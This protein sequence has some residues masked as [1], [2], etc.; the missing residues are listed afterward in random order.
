MMQ[1]IPFLDYFTNVTEIFWQIINNNTLDFALSKIILLQK[2]AFWAFSPQL[3][4]EN[5]FLK[6]PFSND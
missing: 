5:G 3:Q 6:Q 1:W 4:N 2:I